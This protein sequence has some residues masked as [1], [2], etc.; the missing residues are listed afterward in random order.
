MP[1]PVIKRAKKILG[2]LERD[3][4]LRE[5]LKG[6]GARTQPDLFASRQDPKLTALVTEIESLDVNTLTPLLALA[7]LSE[8]KK[9]LE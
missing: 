4:S 3:G 5:R 7:K 2:E 8:L 1:A 6:D 9:M